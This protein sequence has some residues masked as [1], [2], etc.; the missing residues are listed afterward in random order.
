MRRALYLASRADVATSPNPKVGC[1]IADGARVVAE[2]RFR[3]DGG[4]H[5]EVDA[6]TRLPPPRQLDRAR[7][8]AYVS[9]EPC[10]IHGR[11][12]P[13]AERLVGEGIRRVYVAA[14]DA[15]P[16]VCG[17]GL[18][19]LRRGGVAVE[20][21]LAQD[22][23]YELARPRTVF[24]TAARP[25][26]ILKQALSADGYVGRRGQRVAITDPMANTLSH[27]WRADVDA[28]LVGAGTVCADQPSL[29]TRLVS[30]ANPHV[31]VLDPR[32]R[33]SPKQVTTHFAPDA[34]RD[35]HYLTG[36][37]AAP[38]A[39]LA[40]LHER[41]IGKLLVEGGPSTIGRFVEREL[42]DEYREWTS[43]Q[44]LRAGTGAPITAATVS[45]VEVAATAVGRDRLRCFRPADRHGCAPPR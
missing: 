3:R 19:V 17:E 14:L 5:A 39:A 37:E 20:F 41:R 8:T 12:P 25:Y 43:P 28:I 10:S 16:G 23:A 6:V 35:V 11:T 4:P 34:T 32:G 24:A 26:V 30:G 2:G 1:V 29:R 45:G 42:W 31:V 22:L 21:G 7:L 13:C 36:S 33:L 27:Q 15:T 38:A 18:A 9:L 44:T 40:Y